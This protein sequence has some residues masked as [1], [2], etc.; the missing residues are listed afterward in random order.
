MP[1]IFIEAAESGYNNIYQ[2]ILIGDLAK[3]SIT[4]EV[5]RNSEVGIF[6]IF[7][8]LR[9]ENEPEIVSNNTDFNSTSP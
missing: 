9:F 4:I 6:A 8:L 5:F 3:N 2:T 1:S 7:V